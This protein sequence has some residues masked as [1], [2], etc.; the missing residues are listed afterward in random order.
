[1]ATHA[2]LVQ[3]RVAAMT[4]DSFN[5]SAI[6]GSAVDIDN[7]NV[8]RLDTQSTTSG[9]AEVWAVTAPTTSASTLNNLWMA[10]SPEVVVTV[11]GNSQYKGL[12]PDPRNFVNLGGKVFDAFQ[13]QVG[14]IIT[15][16]DP[17][18]TGSAESAY[19]N[20]SNGVYTLTW[21]A[22]VTASAFSLKYLATTYVS[23]ATGAIN[24]QRVT[25][26]KF[27]VVAN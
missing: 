4:V 10:Y 16:T 6:A 5:R 27:Q 17:A 7:G 8:F 14:D 19:A 3:N 1:M 2:I 12:D 15:L 13:P 22:S 18:L 26:Y 24:T 21:G 20:S 25:A 23:L 9:E 11:S